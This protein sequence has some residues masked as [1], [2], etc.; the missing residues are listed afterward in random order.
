MNERNATK[1]IV[2]MHFNRKLFVHLFWLLLLHNICTKVI[3]NSVWNWNNRKKKEKSNNFG[4]R[5]NPSWIE[6]STKFVSKAR[7]RNIPS[8]SFHLERKKKK[9]ERNS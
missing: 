6:S 3:K 1:H 7:I 2:W 8:A 4:L 5:L 9:K